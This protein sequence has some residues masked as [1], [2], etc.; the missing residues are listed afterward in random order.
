MRLLVLLVLAAELCAGC[1][2]PPPEAPRD[3]RAHCAEC[4]FEAGRI[5]HQEMPECV[6]NLTSAF[7]GESA[8]PVAKW[9]LLH[10]TRLA[11]RKSANPM[12]FREYLR[13]C[14]ER[15]RRR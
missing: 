2:A 5:P 4:S 15:G 3:L 12:D 8:K 11:D 1:D 13:A 14:L 6:A 10:C 7:N 9:L